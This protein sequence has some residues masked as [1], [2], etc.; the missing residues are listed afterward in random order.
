MSDARKI[1]GIDLGTTYSAIAH[2][3]EYGKVDIVP[4]S[5]GE[6]ITPSVILFD[7]DEVIVGKVAKNQAVASP[8][9]V[10]QFV[11]R[12]IGEQDWLQTINGRDY[13][14]E[15]LSALIL[16][17]IVSDAEDQLGVEITDVVITVPAYFNDNERKATEDAGQ[18]AGLSVLGLL[19]EPTAAAIAYGMNNLDKTVKA[20]VYDLGG[21]TFDVTV[22]DIE[23]NN[24][25][26]LATA[27]ERRLGGKDWDDYM[28][29]HVAE[30]FID[31]HGIDPRDDLEAYQDLVIKVEDAK[32]TLSRKKEVKIFAQCGGKSLKVP[33]TRETF[34][35][36]TRPLLEQT[37]TYVDM[38]LSKAG[39]TW[40]QIDEVVPVGGSTR[41]PMV[42]EMLTRVTGKE[43]SKGVNPDEC[44]AAGAAYWAAILAVRQGEELQ[45][46][47][48][49]GTATE[50]EADF[51]DMSRQVEESLPEEVTGL[52]RGTVV[53]NVNSHSL[54]I[55][56]VTPSGG[57]RNV[58]MIP[59]QTELPAKVTKIFGTADDNQV[60]VDVNIVEGE[61]ED[62]EDCVSIGTLMIS[63]L[64]PNRPKGSKVRV[65]YTYN[66]DGRIEIYAQDEDTG[67][68]A[69]TDIK[70]TSEGLSSE[71]MEQVGT[72]IASMLE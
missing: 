58:I 14:P 63:D 65:T 29:N 23:G 60:T 27:G 53:K 6:R 32:K 2:F 57:E 66:E 70:R 26:V 24:V 18:I 64:P 52:L 36:L 39:L 8:E 13:T 43:P 62:P 41:M 33:V 42:H 34:E 12:Y 5:E 30:A 59:E 45:S 46:K 3:N 68:E 71:Q 17:R 56:V 51:A 61:S 37:E 19:N 16:K 4:N 25:K 22:L 44:V 55:V 21:G 20:V 10:I 7:E 72:E 1:A 38:V 50:E 48:A 47:V 40:D 69:R 15:I 35:D 31:E 49:A 28:L 67:A 11:K 54:G 9:N